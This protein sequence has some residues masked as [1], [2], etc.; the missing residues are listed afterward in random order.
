MLSDRVRVTAREYEPID[1]DVRESEP[2]AGI[3]SAGREKEPLVAPGE[4]STPPMRPYFSSVSGMTGVAR[5]GAPV[6]SV[7]R[8]VDI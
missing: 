4:S 5:L 7:R 2:I 3:R 1:T 8:V 6:R